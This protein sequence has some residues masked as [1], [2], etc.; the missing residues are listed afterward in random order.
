MV[1]SWYSPN[2]ES[3][4]GHISLKVDVLDAPYDAPNVTII[5]PIIKGE[6][7]SSIWLELNNKV[8]SINAENREFHP[9]FE[10]FNLP[11]FDLVQQLEITHLEQGILSNYLDGIKENGNESFLPPSL[12]AK[13]IGQIVFLAVVVVKM[14][15]MDR[16]KGLGVGFGI[17]HKKERLPLNLRHL[18][19]LVRLCWIWI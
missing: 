15:G 17:G 8:T 11:I 4:T 9:L 7:L 10:D 12:L 1:S 19:E 2:E 5:K 13:K 14:V 18:V 3:A 16:Q 6:D